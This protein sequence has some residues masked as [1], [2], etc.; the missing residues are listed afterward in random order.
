MK[1]KTKEKEGKYVN[2]PI[3]VGSSEEK[4]RKGK[5]KRKKVKM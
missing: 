4:I 5:Q 2:Y 3:G 1:G